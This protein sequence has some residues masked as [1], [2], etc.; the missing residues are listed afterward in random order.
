MGS[1]G[2]FGVGCEIRIIVQSVVGSCH[3]WGQRVLYSVRVPEEVEE[4]DFYRESQAG[5]SEPDFIVS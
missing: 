1:C 2:L 4:E 3:L 5:G